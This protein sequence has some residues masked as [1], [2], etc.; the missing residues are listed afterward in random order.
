MRPT[1]LLIALFCLIGVHSYADDAKASILANLKVQVHPNDFALIDTYKDSLTL[2]QLEHIQNFMLDAS[3]IADAS[4]FDV[5][6]YTSW[7]DYNYYRPID[8]QV[9]TI[10]ARRD[11]F[12]DSARQLNNRM[13]TNMSDEALSALTFSQVYVEE[14]WD[15]EPPWDGDTNTQFNWVHPDLL[16]QPS[17][18]RFLSGDFLYQ[19]RV[20]YWY[21]T[22]WSVLLDIARIF[23]WGYGSDEVFVSNSNL[24]PPRLAGYAYPLGNQLYL[25]TAETVYWFSDYLQ[26]GGI[27]KCSGK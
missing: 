4:W 1:L 18:W 10:L 22:Y 7:D 25:G 24:N 2:Q 12:L 14:T 19:E 3:Q 5:S 26:L 27:L 11:L 23:D 6:L 20:G 21:A 16:Q 13:I 17:L 8:N 15:Q 9:I